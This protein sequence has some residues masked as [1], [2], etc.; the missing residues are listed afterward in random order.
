MLRAL[1]AIVLLS[2]GPVL[3][4]C[5]PTLRQQDTVPSPALAD[6]IDALLVRNPCVGSLDHWDREYFW[7]LNWW[8]AHRVWGSRW[9]G[10]DRSIVRVQFKQAGVFGVGPG[11]RLT[12]VEDVQFEYDDRD[13]RVVFATYDVA[14]EILA[15]EY[16]GLNAF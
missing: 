16:C 14:A 8:S 9:L 12:P 13:Y 10:S 5:Q 6:K 7:G 15:T 1:P 2:A 11:R 3:M 4:A